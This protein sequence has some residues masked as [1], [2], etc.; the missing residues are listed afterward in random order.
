MKKRYLVLAL[1]SCILLSG[2]NFKFSIGETQTAKTETTAE[3]ESS[4]EVTEKKESKES[5]PAEGVSEATTESKETSEVQGV[6][7]KLEET[8]SSQESEEET[9]ESDEKVVETEMTTVFD[10]DAVNV[11]IQEPFKLPTGLEVTINSTDKM[12]FDITVKN[13]SDK[14]A[15]FHI[16]DIACN[17]LCLQR[18]DAY[19]E[20]IVGNSEAKT[21]IDLGQSEWAAV[22][23]NTPPGLI[24]AKMETYPANA[25][26]MT[27]ENTWDGYLLLQLADD[28][29]SIKAIEFADGWVEAY[30]KD[31]NQVLLRIGDSMRGTGKA[32]HA[33][34]VNQTDYWDF[35]SLTLSSDGEWE[36]GVTIGA[37]PDMLGLVEFDYADVVENL[38][39]LSISIEVGEDSVENIPLQ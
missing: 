1:S 21:H 18:T 4:K 24:I 20:S 34:Y 35:A 36:D 23:G 17:N 33:I 27:D 37:Y 32:L 13:T 14:A 15:T 38:S 3:V 6:P 16:S 25:S 8:T 5:E 30:N 2:C 7:T 11:K 22:S 28:M 10:E 19:L 12:S 29:S 9:S 31:G 39:K 26:I